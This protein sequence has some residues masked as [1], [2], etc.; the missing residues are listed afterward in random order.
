L[1]LLHRFADLA[2]PLLTMQLLAA[3]LLTTPSLHL[4][5]SKSLRCLFVCISS[6]HV[7]LFS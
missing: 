7:V 5:I 4:L 3:P 6:T 2:V 1:I